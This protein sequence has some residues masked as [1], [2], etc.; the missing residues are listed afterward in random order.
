M[1]KEGYPFSLLKMV[2]PNFISTESSQETGTEENHVLN[3]HQTTT[4]TVK[5]L[6][7]IKYFGPKP[8]VREIIGLPL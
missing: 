3:G 7:N 5:I 6:S 2:Q 1:E 4:E 8:S